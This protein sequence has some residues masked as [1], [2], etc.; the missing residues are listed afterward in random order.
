[1]HP[2]LPQSALSSRHHHARTLTRGFTLIEIMVVVVILAILGALVAPQ[3]LGRI[4]EA[5]VTKAKAD[6]RLYA[7]ALDMYRMDNFKYPS[8]DY[9]L[10]ALVKK[11]SDPNLTNW[12]ADGYVQLIQKDPWGHDYVYVSPG[13]N[14]AAFDLYSLGAD[15]AVGGTGLDADIS[16]RDSK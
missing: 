7:S 14:G 1:M 2:L 9:G 4:D 16:Y 5:R 3:I 6:L 11:P 8:T 10:E 12:R 13:T 15:G